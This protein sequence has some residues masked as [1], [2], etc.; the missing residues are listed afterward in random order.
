M[1]WK[2]FAS[3]A[4]L[5]LGVTT[6]AYAAEATGAIT[7]IDATGLSVTLDDGNT[8]DFNNPEC[9]A[10]A[11][12]DLSTYQVGDKVLIVWEDMQGT[13]VGMDI[14]SQSN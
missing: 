8:Y 11:Q 4:V 2:I 5:A 13:R 1:N 12:C 14:S 7:E 9:R 10:E 3:A 6:T